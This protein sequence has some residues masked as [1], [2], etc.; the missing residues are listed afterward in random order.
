[1][2]NSDYSFFADR[3]KVVLIFSAKAQVK[4][5]CLHVNLTTLAN[6][7]IYAS[8]VKTQMK[9]ERKRDFSSSLRLAKKYAA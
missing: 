6:R 5:T 1:M 9:N 7:S 2:F 3:L 8:I 4:L